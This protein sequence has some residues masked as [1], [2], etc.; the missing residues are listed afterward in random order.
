MLCEKCGKELSEHD[1]RYHGL[2]QSCYKYYRD[3]GTD[4]PLPQKGCVAH[5]IRG[6]VICHVCGRAYRRL[7]SHVTEV[8]KMS[9]SQY[10]K[11]YGLCTK[12]KTTERSYSLFMREKAYKNGMDKRIV[13]LGMD[14]RFQCKSNKI[15]N[16]DK[17]W[18]RKVDTL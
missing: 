1:T 6:Y 17:S 13:E 12:T 18:N 8:H 9:I 7:G 16:V 2:C 4:N 11:E 14:T 3:G 5:D 10:K 15:G